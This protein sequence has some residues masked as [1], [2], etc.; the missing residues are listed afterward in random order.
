MTQQEF[1]TLLDA[2]RYSP[3]VTVV[4]EA[5][6]RLGEHKHPWDALALITEGE[7]TLVVGGASTRYAAGESF[8]LPAGTLHHES[9]G[10]AGVTLLSGRREVAAP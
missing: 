9:A 8:S 2:G 1:E 6:Y 5:G 4:R 7:I 3:A 10:P